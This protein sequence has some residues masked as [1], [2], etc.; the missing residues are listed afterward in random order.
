MASEVDICNDA[1]GMLGDKANVSAINPPDTSA[2]AGHCARFY[3]MCRD[4]L[5]EAHAWNFATKRVPLAQLSAT[6][7][8]WQF[9]YAVPNDCLKA[10]TVIDPQAPDDFSTPIPLYGVWPYPYPGQNSTP[11]IYS[12]MP[13]VIEVDTNGNRI[14]Y[15]NQQNAQL[16]YI[17]GITDT[18]KFSASFTMALAVLLSSKLAGPIIKGKEGRE[19]AASIRQEFMAVWFPRA[20][21]ADANQRRTQIAQSVP[22][23]VN[24]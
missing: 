16:S 8:Q 6:S 12:P 22:W 19:V 9:I 5:L 11:S 1:L 20:A 15:T 7:S 3:P 13:F 10:L 14:L 4:E 21:M 2:Q 17:A 24:R 18:T 23:M